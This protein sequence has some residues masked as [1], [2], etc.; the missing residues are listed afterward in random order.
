MS[1]YDYELPEEAIAQVP[2]ERR[3]QARLL[4]ALDPDR[5]VEHRQVTDLPE[6]LE[7]GD[8]LVVNETR[9]LPALDCFVAC[10]V[11]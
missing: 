9:V 1:A 2:M 10:A 4:V 5:P 11:E 3:D 6:L 7:P 8:V